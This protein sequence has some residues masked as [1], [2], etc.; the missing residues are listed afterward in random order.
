MLTDNKEKRGWSRMLREIIRIAFSHT[1]MLLFGVVWCGGVWF[2]LNISFRNA[3]L[4]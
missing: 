3:S 2:V 4:R 1:P